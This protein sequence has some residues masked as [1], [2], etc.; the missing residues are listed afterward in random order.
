MIGIR[1]G[2]PQH[3]TLRGESDSDSSGER[4]REVA[5][6]APSQYKEMKRKRGRGIVEIDI[7]RV[8]IER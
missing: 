6:H 7:E 2:N 3:A 4:D 5:Q 1:T 8:E